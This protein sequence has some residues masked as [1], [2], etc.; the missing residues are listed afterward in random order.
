[1]ETWTFAFQSAI[2]NP[3][4]AILNP[5]LVFSFSKQFPFT[6]PAGGYMIPVR[7]TFNHRAARA[8]VRVSK[9]LFF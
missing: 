8:V 5:S 1:L 7:H 4:S 6:A 2:R 3:K 9:G